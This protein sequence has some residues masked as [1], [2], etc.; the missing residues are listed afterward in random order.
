MD[1]GTVRVLIADDHPLVVG[2]LREAVLAAAPGAEI[3][4]AHDFDS[5]AAALEASPETDLVLLDLEHAGRS[6]LFRTACSCDRNG[7]PRRC[8]RGLRK[9]GPRGH[10]ALPR[11]R[12]VGFHSQIELA[13]DDEP[14]I[15]QVLEGGRWT[16]PDFDPNAQPNRE[17]SA[18]ARRLATLT[19]AADPRADDA[20]AGPPEQTD[21]L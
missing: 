9:R 8:H 7:R 12:R 15:A 17:S 21:R 3:A 6:G 5:M 18:L 10:P 2:G 11:V 19:P 20:V 16:P 14:A 4:V 1:I 13:R